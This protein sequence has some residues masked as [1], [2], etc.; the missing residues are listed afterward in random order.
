MRK[1]AVVKA[2]VELRAAEQKKLF[3]AVIKMIGIDRAIATFGEKSVKWAITKYLA[4][5]REKSR[6]LREQTAA[7]E[8]IAEINRKLGI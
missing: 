5:A 2:K 3:Q 7:E 8:R 6:L 1:T 4:S